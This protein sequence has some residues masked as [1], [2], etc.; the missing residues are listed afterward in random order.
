[1]ARR[2]TNAMGVVSVVEAGVLG[3]LGVEVAVESVR[4]LTNLWN[5]VALEQSMEVLRVV[6]LG[7]REHALVNELVNGTALHGGDGARPMS[8]R[9]K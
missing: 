2:E 1:M 4:F 5:Q 3:F 7:T 6:A 8:D 9:L